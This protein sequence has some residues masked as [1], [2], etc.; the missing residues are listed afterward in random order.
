VCNWF[1]AWV[2][3]IWIFDR[4]LP[5][6]CGGEIAACGVSE[7]GSIPGVR[8]LFSQIFLW[9]SQSLGRPFKTLN[10][11]LVSLS[12][13]RSH[14]FQN[15]RFFNYKFI[16]LQGIDIWMTEQH[17]PRDWCK[18][19]LLALCVT[20]F[21]ALHVLNAHILLNIYVKL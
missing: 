13:D 20:W 7:P 8:R 18:W 10:R 12:N 15:K 14:V 17:G 6:W 4:L 19:S 11:R 5:Y 1:S 3:C 2:G 21:S 16:I 9:L